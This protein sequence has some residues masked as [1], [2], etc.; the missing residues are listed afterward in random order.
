MVV[1]ERLLDSDPL[2]RWQVMHD[3][4]EWARRGRRRRALQGFAPYGSC[5]GTSKRI[6][7]RC[8]GASVRAVSG[9]PLG[10]DP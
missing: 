2:I 7:D 1:V 6:D 4:T 3:L 5:A 8:L 10:R 9:V